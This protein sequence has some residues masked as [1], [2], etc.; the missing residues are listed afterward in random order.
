VANGDPDSHRYIQVGYI[1]GLTAGDLLYHGKRREAGHWEMDTV[2]GGAPPSRAICLSTLT[3]RKTCAE[4]I[5]KLPNGNASSAVTA[6]NGIE[7]SLGTNV[8]TRIFKSITPDTWQRHHGLT[9]LLLLVLGNLKNIAEKIILQSQPFFL[10]M[11]NVLQP[12]E[13]F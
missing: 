7:R 3:E 8:F 5:R 4:I 10:Y 11:Q 12:W 6:I 9:A 13:G 1:D 2:K